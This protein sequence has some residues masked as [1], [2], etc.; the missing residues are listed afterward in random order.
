MNISK[1]EKVMLSSLGIVLVGVIYYQFIYT[2]QIEKVDVLES[3]RNEVKTKYN[4]VMDTIRTLE[5]KN[6]FYVF[7]F[8]YESI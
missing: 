1:R 2:K 3:Q 7:N 8:R 4:E 5:Q 6:K